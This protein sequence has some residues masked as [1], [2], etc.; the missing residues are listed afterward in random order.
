L[1]GNSAWGG[2]RWQWCWREGEWAE[3]TGSRE[4][5]R[6]GG[7]AGSR[8]RRGE[9]KNRLWENGNDRRKETHLRGKRSSKNGPAPNDIRTLRLSRIPRLS[10]TEV[11]GC[12]RWMMTRRFGWP[13]GME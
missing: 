1:K 6:P 4:V 5:H 9:P 3:Q 8:C 13:I 10:V 11:E 12:C 7:A 2:A